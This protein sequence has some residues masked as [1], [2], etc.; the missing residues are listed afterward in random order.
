MQFNA[1]VKYFPSSRDV[2]SFAAASEHK[3]SHVGLRQILD[4]TKSVEY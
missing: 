4:L 3:R 2:D 1:V